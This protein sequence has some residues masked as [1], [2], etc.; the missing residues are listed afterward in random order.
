[1][2]TGFELGT[3]AIVGL[4]Q[5]YNRYARTS[6]RSNCAKFTNKPYRPESD[7]WLRLEGNVARTI[8]VCD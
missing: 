8:R 5:R 4:I 1:M 2:R 7:F 3:S 6:F